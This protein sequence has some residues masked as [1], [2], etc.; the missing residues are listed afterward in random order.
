MR[1]EKDSLGEKQVPKEAY[2]GIQTLRGFENFPISGLKEPEV[3]IQAYVFIKKAAAAVNMALD[4]LDSKIGKAI[5]QA[6]DEVLSG[7]FHDQFIIDVFQAGAGTSFN[8]NTNEVLANRACEILGSKKGDYAKVNP[9]DHVNMA[10]STNDTFPTAM[11]LST[12]FE[13]TP[14][15]EALIGLIDSF[16]TKGKEFDSVATSSRTHLQDAVPIRLGQEFEAYAVM[17]EKALRRIKQAKEALTHL[18]LGAT[19]SGTG[20]NSHP[21]YA[22]KMAETLSSLTKLPLKNPDNFIEIAQSTA[23][24]ADYSS[25]LKNLALDLTKIVNDLRLLGSGPRVGL[26][27]IKLPAVQPGS[28]IMPGKVNPSIL[29]C[30]NMVCYQVIGNDLTVSMASQA[31]QLQLNVMMPVMIYNL[32]FSSKILTNMMKMLSLKCIQGIS[33]NKEQCQKYFEETLGL[34]TA[35]NPIIGYAKAAEV[36]K[37]SIKTGTSILKMIEQKGILTKDEIQKY[38]SPE[39]L[40]NPGILKKSE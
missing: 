24:F 37:E 4:V 5:I 16:R 21:Q 28:S 12:L 30:S 7:K 22:E 1:I 27:E 9:N 19:A 29:E 3:L 2:Y 26:N 20:M 25:A 23:D 39:R 40:T 18:N 13:Y 35:L 32:L 34:A 8:M 14:L 10:Q 33:A 6:A 11:R 38:L 36:V 15:K 31:G 17:L